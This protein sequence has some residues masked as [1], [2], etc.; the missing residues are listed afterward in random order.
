MAA[1]L[2]PSLASPAR[3]PVWRLAPFCAAAFGLTV[4]APLWLLLLA[5]LVLGVPHVIAD[6]RYLLFSRPAASR[7]LAWALLLPFA[8]LT[9]LRLAVVFGRAGWPRVEVLLGLASVVVAVG[10]ARAAVWKRAVALLGVFALGAFAAARPDFVAL[11]L[12]H[13]HNVIALGLWLVWA[14]ASS[15]DVAAAIALV[16]GG[17][18]AILGGV[19]DPMIAASGALA[20]PAAGLDLA[21]LADTLA[22]G[23]APVAAARVVL[24]F[25]FAQALHYAVWLVLLPAAARAGREPRGLLTSLRADLG[26][27]GAA[28]AVVASVAV[29]LAGL[30]DAAGTRAVYLSLVLFHGWLEVALIARGAVEHEAAPWR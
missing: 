15:R 11:A 28:A 27:A 24:L 13:L 2:A 3:S 30:V 26:R 17:A 9:A 20:A 22:P 23:L 8:P 21:A 19:I 14:R 5:P 10:P 29:P 18:L 4:F 16:G 25:A 7:R 1:A 12:G 6:L